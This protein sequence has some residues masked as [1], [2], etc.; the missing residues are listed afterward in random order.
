MVQ[1]GNFQNV[2]RQYIDN[3]SQSDYDFIQLKMAGIERKFGQLWRKPDT[4]ILTRYQKS[5]Q[6]MR[7]GSSGSLHDTDRPYA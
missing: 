4:A 5:L 3:T 2:K 7:V 6:K 1:N